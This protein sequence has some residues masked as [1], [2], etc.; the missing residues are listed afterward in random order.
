MLLPLYRGENQELERVSNLE[1]FRRHLSNCY[2]LWDA[3]LGKTDASEMV[4]WPGDMDK[5]DCNWRCLS[6]VSLWP[7]SGGAA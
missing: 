4:V 1:S 6:F 7:F 3:V 5:Q 2:S